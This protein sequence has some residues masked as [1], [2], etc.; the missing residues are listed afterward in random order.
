MS[1]KNPF[2]SV[3]IPT[4]NGE[5]CIRTMLDSIRSQTFNDYELI[6]VCDACEDNTEQVVKKYGAKIVTVD[7]HRD[8]LTRNAGLDIAKGE[9]IIFADDDDWF[10]HEYVFSM[11]HDVVGKQG[12]DMLNFSYVKHNKGYREQTPDNL[13]MTC[14][15][16]CCKRSLIG[17][18]R[19]TNASFGSDLTFFM[20]LMSKKPDMV[21]WN[22]PIYYYNAN[23]RSLNEFLMDG[24][25]YE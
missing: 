5:G 9:W 20:D 23:D 7:Y 14:W 3:I 6:V 22:T 25:N 21:F 11:L 13:F 10:I 2:F 17:D 16:R 15:C 4:H 24:G 1:E 18:T 19:F 12:E 8:G